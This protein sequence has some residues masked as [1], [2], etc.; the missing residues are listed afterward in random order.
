MGLSPVID[1]VI[2]ADL[3]ITAFLQP[4]RQAVAD[5]VVAGYFSRAVLGGHDLPNFGEALF[6]FSVCLIFK[7]Q[8]AHEPAALAR[9]FGGVQ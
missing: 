5:D 6:Q 9:N 2:K 1:N 4:H 3:Y 7:G 8:A